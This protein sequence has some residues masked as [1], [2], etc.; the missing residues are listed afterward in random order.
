MMAVNVAQQQQSQ[1]DAICRQPQDCTV[2]AGVLVTAA[3]ACQVHTSHIQLLQQ[4]RLVQ[5][6]GPKWK[7]QHDSHAGTSASGT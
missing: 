2:L 5:L 6:H 7:N 1:A 3:E 4:Q